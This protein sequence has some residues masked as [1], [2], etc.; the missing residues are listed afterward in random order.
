MEGKQVRSFKRKKAL[1]YFKGTAKNVTLLVL[2]DPS[3]LIPHAKR[4]LRSCTPFLRKTLGFVHLWCVILIPS[5][6]TG[7]HAN[8]GSAYACYH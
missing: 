6:C 8:L 2:N 3:P 1:N 5:P 7:L 4:N